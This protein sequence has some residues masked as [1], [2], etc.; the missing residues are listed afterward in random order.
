MRL[1][2]FLA[3]HPHESSG[4]SRGM[5]VDVSL[6]RLKDGARVEL[7]SAY[8]EMSLRSYRDFPGEIVANLWGYGYFGGRGKGGLRGNWAMDRAELAAGAPAAPA[9]A[10][11]SF[12]ATRRPAVEYR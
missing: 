9:A 7:T 5:T 11:S 3:D 6:Y 12:G 4:Y 1:Q 10:C 8:G 2:R